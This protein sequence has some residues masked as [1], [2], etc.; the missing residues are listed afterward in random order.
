[1]ELKAIVSGVLT[2]IL[3]LILYIALSSLIPPEKGLE[4]LAELQFGYFLFSAML[5]GG[6]C[7]YFSNKFPMRTG[8]LVGIIQVLLFFT[9]TNF[10]FNTGIPVVVFINNITLCTLS[11]FYTYKIK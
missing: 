9:L 3:L 6:A 7:G 2:S 1:M 10:N 4:L 8:F 11:A 5:S